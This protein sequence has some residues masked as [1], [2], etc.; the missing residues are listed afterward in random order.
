MMI[1]YQMLMEKFSQIEN[2][3]RTHSDL[4]QQLRTQAKSHTSNAR[5]RD[6]VH[7]SLVPIPANFG[8]R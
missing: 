6:Y 5:M 2:H 3:H 4:I 7:D 8:D 1:T